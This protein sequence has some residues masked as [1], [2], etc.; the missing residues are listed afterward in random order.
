MTDIHAY[1]SADYGEARA[2]FRAACEAAGLTIDTWRHPL[3]GMQRE[4][5]A[6]DAAWIGP[7]DAQRVLLATS[8]SIAFKGGS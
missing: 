8:V 6:T 7:A 1:F 4:V 2:K 5:L 3:P